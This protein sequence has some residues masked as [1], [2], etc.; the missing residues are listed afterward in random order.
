MIADSSKVLFNLGLIHATLANHRMAVAYYEQ[1][2]LLDQ[3]LAVSF[4]QYVQSAPVSLSWLIPCNRCGVSH[5]LLGDFTSAEQAFSNAYVHMR[6][7]Q[8]IE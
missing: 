1:A 5:F 3:Y 6:E 8:I 4:F 2:H 7:N